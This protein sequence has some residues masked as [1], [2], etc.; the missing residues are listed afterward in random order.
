MVGRQGA[1]AAVV[2]AVLHSSLGKYKVSQQ[3]YRYRYRYKAFE[4]DEK[5]AQPTYLRIEKG[6]DTGYSKG[7]DT[8]Q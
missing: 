7:R 6:C 1:V 8:Q 2:A 4:S 3:R 5:A